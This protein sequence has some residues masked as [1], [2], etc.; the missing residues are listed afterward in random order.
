MTN[1]YT[2]LGIRKTATA[3]TIRKAYRKLSK[4]FHPDRNPGDDS[5]A[6]KFAAVDAAY[7]ILS[8]PDRKAKYDATGEIDSPKTDKS[9]SELAQTLVPV[10][11]N[12][13]EQIAKKDGK[14][15]QEDIV[16]HMRTI[17]E[18][19]EKQLKSR[20]AEL[21]K[22]NTALLDSVERFT[23]ADGEENLLSAMAKN[24][25][26]IVGASLAQIDTDV[27][28]IKAALEYL[29]KCGYRC[30]AVAVFTFSSR[31]L[32]TFQRKAAT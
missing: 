3:E 17:L 16:S 27:A 14:A 25:L 10:L 30:D 8:D 6:V 7:R 31:S 15:T 24:Q 12:V 19:G 9:L 22:I 21:M 18:G 13:M 29:R 11:M 32:F 2:T 20:R 23:A 1:L 26:Q 28:K 4:K 5:V